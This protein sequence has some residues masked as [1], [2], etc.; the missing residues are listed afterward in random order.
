MST[1][2]GS[3]NR[4]NKRSVSTST[5]TVDQIDPEMLHPLEQV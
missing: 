5:S 1:E 2:I 3:L 4:N